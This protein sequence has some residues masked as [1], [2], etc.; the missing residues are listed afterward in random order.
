MTTIYR[1]HLKNNDG[2]KCLKS[3]YSLIE[4]RDGK[5]NYPSLSPEYVNTPE[6]ITRMKDGAEQEVNETSNQAIV[7]IN[8]TSLGCK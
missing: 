2:L 3:L 6:F 5:P 4:L 7:K 8:K 1:R